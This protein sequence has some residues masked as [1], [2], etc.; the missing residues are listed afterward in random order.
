[1]PR[2]TRKGGRFLLSD[3]KIA[4]FKRASFKPENYTTSEMYKTE[5]ANFV[6]NNSIITP[7]SLGTYGITYKLILHEEVKSPYF[8]IAGHKIESQACTADNFYKEQCLTEVRSFLLK[9]SFI[10]NSTDKIYTQN[11]KYAFTKV[12]LADFQQEAQIQDKIY[13]KTFD[14]ANSLVPACVAPALIYKTNHALF[15]RLKVED[16]RLLTLNLKN[17]ENIGLI[18]MEFAEGYIPLYSI[19]YNENLLTGNPARI[20]RTKDFSEKAAT[21]FSLYQAA[22]LLLYKAGWAHGDYHYGNVMINEEKKEVLLI[23]FGQTSDISQEQR[24]EFLPANFKQIFTYLKTIAEKKKFLTL[25]RLQILDAFISEFH[26]NNILEE[27]AKKSKLILNRL[28]NGSKDSTII[29]FVNNP[30]FT[31]YNELRWYQSSL[32]NDSR[33]GTPTQSADVQSPKPITPF[34]SVGSD[35]GVPANSNKGDTREQII[36]LFRTAINNAVNDSNET[37]VTKLLA[38][39]TPFKESDFKVIKNNGVKPAA[40]TRHARPIPAAAAI[41]AHKRILYY[42]PFVAQ[43]HN[44][45]SFEDLLYAELIKQPTVEAA[46]SLLA[47]LRSILIERD[48]MGRT[49]LHKAAILSHFTDLNEEVNSIKRNV[50]TYTPKTAQL[51]IIKALIDAEPTLPDIKDNNGTKSGNEYYSGIGATRSYIK[52]R[53]EEGGTLSALK[54]MAGIFGGKSTRRRSSRASYRAHPSAHSS[55]AF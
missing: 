7:V 21:A 54:K 8:K 25:I 22:H 29:K 52:R 39:L 37:E 5:L 55:P 34:S 53:Q 48:D 36:D 51:Q 12:P 26:I 3:A 28:L 49:I 6:I 11:N 10:G 27:R 9:L 2:Q 50:K 16:D 13:E 31:N 23:D 46:N 33:P 19:L 35:P 38:L 1:M 42:R 18:L 17:Q 15:T 41:A 45:Q 44:K 4:E 30:T 47:K 43:T 14:L 32:Y 40:P 20:D 24:P